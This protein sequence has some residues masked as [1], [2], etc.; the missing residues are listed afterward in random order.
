MAPTPPAQPFPEEKDAYFR[1]IFRQFGEEQCPF[2]VMN[3]VH[4]TLS[5]LLFSWLL[6]PLLRRPLP[7]AHRGIGFQILFILLVLIPLC[8]LP[9]ILLV[10]AN[11]RADEPSW[12]AGPSTAP[13]FLAAARRLDAGAFQLLYEWPPCRVPDFLFGMALGQLARNQRVL[14][15]SGWPILVDCSALMLLCILLATPYSSKEG[16]RTGHEALFISGLNPLL[17]VILL[18]SN[19]ESAADRSV[20]TRVASMPLLH[21]AG[22]FSFHVYLLQEV[23]AKLFLALQFFGRGECSGVA[24]CVHVGSGNAY[25]SRGHLGSQYWLPFLCALWALGASWYTHVE[26]PW[27]RWLRARLAFGLPCS[28]RQGSATAPKG[29]CS[30]P[31][32]A[33]SPVTPGV[34][35]TLL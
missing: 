25:T 28:T 13:G 9:L 24:H 26:E 3:N 30:R 12:F 8:S 10:R 27:V 2:T 23:V 19:A 31:P 32:L 15:W 34:G 22:K 7:S 5:T 14:E 1:G 17:G 16:G 6:Y 21:S 33:E 18:G 20:V 4:W 11:R 29:S 35:G